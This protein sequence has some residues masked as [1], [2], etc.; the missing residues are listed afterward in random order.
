[1]LDYTVI[2]RLICPEELTTSKL[3]VSS[4]F[5]KEALG[6]ASVEGVLC[7]ELNESSYVE[8]TDL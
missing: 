3:A 1:M 4:D 2:E 8:V 6:Q 5:S 7:V